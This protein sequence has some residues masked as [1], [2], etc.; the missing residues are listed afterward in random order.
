VLESRRLWVPVSFKR[1]LEYVVFRYEDSPARYLVLRILQK[2]IRMHINV[3]TY[4]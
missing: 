2:Y 4:D 1:V 3:C